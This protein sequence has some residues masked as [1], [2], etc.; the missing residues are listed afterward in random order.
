WQGHF[1]PTRCAGIAAGRNLQN[2][3]PT[4]IA[5]DAEIY[6]IRMYLRQ[7]ADRI[8]SLIEAIDFAIAEGIDILN[9]SIHITENS[10]RIATGKGSSEGTPKHM[11]IAMRNA[12][13]KA[14]KHGIIIVVAAGN[15][16]DGDGK[17]DIEF[18]QLLPKMPGVITV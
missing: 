7:Y 17:D 11:R 2:G 16:N 5:P 9:M 18:G 10:F 3:E 12:F 6:S 8:K 15:M 1:H 14:Y 13:Y 4:G